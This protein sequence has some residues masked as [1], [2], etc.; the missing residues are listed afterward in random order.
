MMM[1]CDRRDGT[2][3]LE[4][5]NVNRRTIE[6]ALNRFIGDGEP[7]RPRDLGVYVRALTHKSALGE[8]VLDGDFERLEFLGDSVL[9]IVVT[10]YIFDRY[11]DRQEGFLTRVRTKLVRTS[12]LAGWASELGLQDLIL[13]CDKAIASGWNLNAKKLEDAFEALV[14]AVFIDLGISACRRFL[15]P[16]LDRSDFGEVEFDSNFKDRLLRIM[17]AAHSFLTARGLNNSGY[18]EEM[19]PVYR[20]RGTFKGPGDQDLFDVVVLVCGFDLGSGAHVK[21]RD[22]EQV[23]ARAGLATIMAHGL[24]QV[25]TRAGFVQIPR[26]TYE[27]ILLA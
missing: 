24:P 25:P 23:A 21:K 13:M 18:G 10:K 27:R 2:V 9:N 22:A 6:A 7:L 15:H 14:G 12:T 11:P 8:Y 4:A 5:R 16:L 26:E 1:E 20:V 19:L 17:Q 3:L